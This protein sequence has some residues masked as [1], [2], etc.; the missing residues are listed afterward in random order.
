MPIYEFQSED[1]EVIERVHPMREAPPIDSVIEVDGKKY[2]RIASG[3]VSVEAA[4]V[5]CNKYPYFSMRHGAFMPGAKHDKQG[6]SFIESPTHER[7][8]MA[9]NNLGRD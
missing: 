2:K 6:R 5:N 9:K 7:E 3:G 8:W 4:K 1:G